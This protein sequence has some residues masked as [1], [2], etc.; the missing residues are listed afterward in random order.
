MPDLGETRR[1]GTNYQV[2][3]RCPTCGLERW[4]WQGGSSGV[5][6]ERR[7]NPCRLVEGRKTMSALRYSRGGY[8]KWQT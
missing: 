4:G 1:H 3:V 2:Y 6:K 7:C 5:T 8:F